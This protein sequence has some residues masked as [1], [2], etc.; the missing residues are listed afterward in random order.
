[1][2]VEYLNRCIYDMYIV[3]FLWSLLLLYHG[4]L[5]LVTHEIQLKLSELYIVYLKIVV[6]KTILS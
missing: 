2:Y 4:T 3:I 6:L 1:M 5:L